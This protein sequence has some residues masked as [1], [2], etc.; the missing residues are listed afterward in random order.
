MKGGPRW[1][2][3]LSEARLARS[4]WGAWTSSPCAAQKSEWMWPEGRPAASSHSSCFPLLGD[5]TKSYLLCVRKGLNRTATQGCVRRALLTA[6]QQRSQVGLQL[7]LYALGLSSSAGDTVD[8]AFPSSRV[9]CLL[10]RT[11]APGI[12]VKLGLKNS[13][14]WLWK[15]WLDVYRTLGLL[16]KSS[17]AKGCVHFVWPSDLLR[18]GLV[19]N[20]F[21]CVFLR[22]IVPLEGILEVN[23]IQVT[24]VPMPGPQ[25]DNSLVDFVVTCQGRWVHSLRGRKGPTENPRLNNGLHTPPTC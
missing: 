12:K 1:K 6:A 17:M 16:P 25:P 21:W 11:Q 10:T 20:V 13:S 18:S 3:A 19:C 4:L 7:K 5:F 14:V 9:I 15:C 22:G 24:D 2:P 23:I 8:E